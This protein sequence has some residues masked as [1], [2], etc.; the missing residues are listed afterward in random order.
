MIYEHVKELADKKNMTIKEIE[1][2]AG[3][4]NGAIGKWDSS[5]PRIDNLQA[6]AKVLETPID[7]FLQ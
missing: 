1:K 2:R 5:M 7:Y 4:A 3:L 6:V